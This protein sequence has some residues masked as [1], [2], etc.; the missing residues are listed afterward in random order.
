M[1][2]YEYYCAKCST[3]FELM[4]AMMHRD[5]TATCPK[6]HAGA[7][8]TLSMFASVRKG[9]AGESMPSGGGCGCGGG[10]CGC[11]GH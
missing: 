7:R 11:G 6:G 1:P 9:A 2:M 8:R 3:T 4:R 10:A 5:A